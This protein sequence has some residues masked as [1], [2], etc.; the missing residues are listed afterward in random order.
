[1]RLRLK[2]LREAADWSPADLSR[3]LGC[4]HSTITRREDGEHDLKLSVLQEYAEA[5]GVPIVD[6]IEGPHVLDETERL[7]LEEVRKMRPRR[8]QAV[9]NTIRS[10]ADIDAA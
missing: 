4:A 8:K 7:I 10:I 1:M 6:L 5:F 9:L 3:K 2:E